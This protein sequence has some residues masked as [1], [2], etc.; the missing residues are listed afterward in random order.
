MIQVNKPADPFTAKMRKKADDQTKSDCDAYDINPLGYSTAGPHRMKLPAV[1]SIY[2]A[3]GRTKSALIGVIRVIIDGAKKKVGKCYF[4]EGRFPEGGL[5]I[6]HYR[7][8][9]G[10]QK[11]R[12]SVEVYPGYF[13]LAYTWDNLILACGECNGA[14]GTIFPLADETVRVLSHIEKNFLIRERPLLINPA[15]IGVDPRDH[16]T[17]ADDAPVSDSAEG[18][19][20]IELL[21]LDYGKNKK[22]RPFLKEE[23]LGLLE[24][25]RV[26]VNILDNSAQYDSTAEGRQFLA[27]TR[28]Y[29]EKAKSRESR[30]SSMAQDF[31]ASFGF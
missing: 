4:C 1:K 20:T 22:E 28:E 18:K 27:E 14:K 24:N 13:W 17:F 3:S 8:K 21:K 30:F 29:L 16:I 5:H 9:N 7:P 26:R 10:F 11:S 31:L 19:A 12:G 25:L 2:D 15:A 23:R 6:E